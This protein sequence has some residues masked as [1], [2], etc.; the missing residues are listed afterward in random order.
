V[1]HTDGVAYEMT[2][3]HTNIHSHTY[4]QA[5]ASSGSLAHIHTSQGPSAR[6]TLLVQSPSDTLHSQQAIHK[7]WLTALDVTKTPMPVRCKLTLFLTSPLPSTAPSAASHAHDHSDGNG[8]LA[9]TRSPTNPDA[10][11]STWRHESIHENL[12]YAVC[13]AARPS[14][15]PT[16]RRGVCTVDVYMTAS[17]RVIHV[18][19]PHS[20]PAASDGVYAYAQQFVNQGMA[21]AGPLFM[22]DLLCGTLFAVDA[23]VVVCTGASSHESAGGQEHA[24]AAGQTQIQDSHLVYNSCME[25]STVYVG[26]D[27][28]PGWEVCWSANAPQGADGDGALPDDP[29]NGRKMKSKLQSRRG[30]DSAGKKIKK[31]NTCEVH[32]CQLAGNLMAGDE[33]ARNFVNRAGGSCQRVLMQMKMACGMQEVCVCVGLWVCVCE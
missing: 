7:T 20:L 27:Q 22:A 29:A 6:A 9:D 4:T 24:T 14:I 25:V 30:S 11:A 15:G 28:L 18:L 13:G 8:S 21:G 3:M 19:L 32:A 23:R 10:H 16:D 17:R 5:P 33:L 2:H 12:A 26:R 31:N 1:S